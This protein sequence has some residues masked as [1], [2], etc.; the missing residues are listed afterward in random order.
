MTLSLDNARLADT[1]P[2]DRS[3]TSPSRKLKFRFGKASSTPYTPYE[4]D[5]E[6]TLYDAD[7]TPMRLSPAAIYH[8]SSTPSVTSSASYSQSNG[9]SSEEGDLGIRRFSN[10]VWRK[11]VL[12]WCAGYDPEMV[13]YMAPW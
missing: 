2:L 6:A 13:V 1:G 10:R 9:S 4:D 12:W 3:Q 5:D 8:P 11:I 7:Y